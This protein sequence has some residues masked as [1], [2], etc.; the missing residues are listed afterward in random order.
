MFTRTPPKSL[1]S[2]CSLMFLSLGGA[3]LVTG[4]QAQNEAARP[5]A[6]DTFVK[7]FRDDLHKVSAEAGAILSPAAPLH[8]LPDR[9]PPAGVPALDADHA[10][11][12]VALNAAADKAYA[13]KKLVLAIELLRQANAMA[14]DD[15]A[16]ILRQTIVLWHLGKHDQAQKQLPFLAS[17]SNGSVAR[18]AARLFGSWK[19][20]RKRRSMPTSTRP[21][22]RISR[23]PSIPSPP[24]DWSGPRAST[25][26][27]R[28]PR[29]D[30]RRF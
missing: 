23:A 18:V 6:E 13:A 21:P 9:L 24:T 22:P 20:P 15:D 2:A 10:P 7:A 3:L 11:T 26:I 27:A 30:W 28:T 14:P 19:R 12:F 8:V 17:S 29:C 5:P 1:R 4:A 16:G 25:G